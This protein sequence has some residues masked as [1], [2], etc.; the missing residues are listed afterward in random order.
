[1]KGT[2]YERVGGLQPGRSAFDL[3]HSKM[4]DCNLGHIVPVLVQDVGPGDIFDLGASQITKMQPMVVPVYHRMDICYHVFFIPYRLIWSSW[5]KFITGGVTGDANVALPCL[6]SEGETDMPTVLAR[7]G[8]WDYAGFRMDADLDN[9]VFTTLPKVQ[10][11]IWRA[12]WAV[13][14][15][16]YRDENFQTVFPGSSI[17]VGQDE[18]EQMYALEEFMQLQVVDDDI[19]RFPADRLAYRCWSKDYF[20]SALPW[21]QRGT[22]PAIPITG[23]AA[24]QWASN[25]FLSED[26]PVNFAPPNW[27]NGNPSILYAKAAKFDNTDGMGS[28]RAA[29]MHA[30]ANS[31]TISLSTVGADIN[32]LRY[33]VQVQKWLERNARGGYRYN[34]YL[35]A[36]FNEAPRDDRL[37][38]P[39]YIGGMRQPIITSE[40]LQTSATET[41]SPQGTFAGHGMSVGQS[42][43]GRYHAREHGIIL[44]LMSIMPEAVYQQGIPRQWTRQTRFD[45]YSPEFAHLSEQEIKLSELYYQNT[46]ADN[47]RFGFQGAYDEYRTANSVVCGKLATSLKYWTLSR[48]FDSAPTL[49]STFLTTEALSKTRRQAWAVPGVE[50]G[51]QGE[52][53]VRWNNHVKALRPMPYIPEPGLL[54]HF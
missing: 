24:A 11:F 42:F 49:N 28:A 6:W 29:N 33:A 9:Q 7:Y 53:L 15:D 18:T 16:Y 52:F 4:F 2:V 26:M 20:T 35:M 32:D 13:W 54:D 23:A 48:I 47:T 19:Y 51:S 25:L 27:D 39:E 1:M 46:D 38:R 17:D 40:V 8:I 3:S 34:E 45:F 50:N 41:E 44:G 30:W 14:R 12:Y 5:Q 22:S 31:N 10:D 36:H 43:T 21:Q 37:Q